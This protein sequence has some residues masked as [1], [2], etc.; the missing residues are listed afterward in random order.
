MILTFTFILTIVSDETDNIDEIMYGNMASE[1]AF[2]SGPE[3]QLSLPPNISRAKSET[4]GSEKIQLLRQQMEENR[5]K[6]AERAHNKKGIEDMVTQM[7]A[8]LDITQMSLEKSTELG[9]SIGDL[10]AIGFGSKGALTKSSSD[11]NYATVNFDKERMR[12]MKRKIID[13][14]SKLKEKDNFIHPDINTGEH[15][16]KIKTL[17]NRILDLEENLK[18]KESIIDARTR[19]VSLMSENLSLKGKNTVDMLEDT[20]QE[21]LKM[22]ENFIKVEND[23]KSDN[24][25]LRI[26][27]EESC[28]KLN[29]YE[30]KVKILEKNRFDLTMKNSELEGKLNDVLDYST[31]L[32]ELNK[33]NEA[34]LK[35]IHYLENQKYDI[36]TDDEIAAAKS[37]SIVENEESLDTNNS[38]IEALQHE[39]LKLREKISFTQLSDSELLEKCQSLESENEKY[40]LELNEFKEKYS[41]LEESL[42]EKTIEYNVLQANFSV[43]E[44][45]LNLSA[46]KPL[47]SKS[48]DEEAELEISKLKSQLDESNKSSIKTKLKLK[49]LQKQID[50]LKKSSTIHEEIVRLT[51]DNQSL[52]HKII[53]LEEEKGQLQL[54]LVH[55]DSTRIVTD[56]D[57]ENKITVLEHTCQ[58]QTS[59]INLLEEQKIDMTENLQKTKEELTTLKEQIKE[60]DDQETTRVSIQYS[61]IELE[62]KLEQYKTEISE[63]S[64]T[65][66]SLKKELD[67][68]E[69]EKNRYV[70]EN[71]ELLDKIDKLSVEKGS[72]NE[73][74]EIVANLTQQ[75]K[76]E[77]EEF[78]KT[79]DVESNLDL[80]DSLVKLREESSELMHKI[81]LFTTERKEVLEKMELISV[82]NSKLKRDLESLEKDKIE[83]LEKLHSI[84]V[85]EVKEVVEVEEKIEVMKKSDDG[86]SRD[87]TFNDENYVRSLKLL[88][89]ELESYKRN[90]EKNTKLKQFKKFASEAQKVHNLLNELLI[91]HRSTKHEM[92]RLES[93]YSVAKQQL[94][95]FDV[96]VKEIEE[97]KLKVSQVSE[98]KI[99]YYLILNLI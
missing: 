4:P 91:I 14:E 62:E 27:L 7:K 50:N 57:L 60:I 8:K 83:L 53:E 12:N 1:I 78:N 34:L 73:S 56:T 21:M 25:V 19:A 42:S 95:T 28:C 33:Q 81:E 80:N 32:S 41:N 36:I 46:P 61:A 59:A 65:N 84:K 74:I 43:L 26:E 63:L 13:L 3:H 5:Q 35:R 72:S 18:E 93:E 31:K 99:L 97:L 44:E 70:L 75:E 86:D 64:I 89:N 24:E 15:L 67:D 85:I 48:T 68:L 71:T 82:E 38:Q 87:I 16:K 6:M 79:Q 94:A 47:F 17:E 98:S 76:L 66:N 22:Q 45:K 30:E 49:Q 55:D 11:L 39:V 52:H 40:R 9:K 90:K 2:A 54:K 20:K 88:E 58:N 92:H 69:V 29:D 51:E 23:Y 37:A 10:S 77:I 96:K